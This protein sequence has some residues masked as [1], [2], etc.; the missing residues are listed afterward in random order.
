M[1]GQHKRGEGWLDSIR[2]VVKQE[3]EQQLVGGGQVGQQKAMEVNRML[4]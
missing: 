4:S 1:V 2:A 3:M